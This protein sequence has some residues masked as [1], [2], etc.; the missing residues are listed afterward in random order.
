MKDYEY[1]AGDIVKVSRMVIGRDD[2]GEIGCHGLARILCGYPKVGRGWHVCMV[3]EFGRNTGRAGYV[4]TRDIE[5]LA[6]T[7]PV[8]RYL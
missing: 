7:E 2:R 8:Y 4:A 6:R 5:R 1:K 3:D